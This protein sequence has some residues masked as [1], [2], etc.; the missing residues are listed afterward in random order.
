MTDKAIRVL[1]V[2]DNPGDVTLMK[3]MLAEAGEGHFAAESASSL[4]AGLERMAAG[5]IDVVL[6]DLT[7]PDAHGLETVTRVRK[8]APKIPVVVLTGLDDEELALASMHTGAQDY[9]VKGSV[10]C[11]LLARSIR[12]AVERTRTERELAEHRRRLEVLLDNV[13]DRIY[14]K[15]EKG[16]FLQVNASLASYHGVSSPVEVCGKTDAD[17]FAFEHANQALEDERE[18]M[19]TGKP[20]IGRVEKETFPDGRVG[21]SSSTK[22]P[23]RDESG[24]IVG[25]CGVS[26]DITSLMVAEEA[27]R[28]SEERYKRLLNSVTD[29][30]YTVEV[31]DGQTVSTSHGAGC[32]AV[33]GYSPDEF[34]ADPWLWH[35]VIHYADRERVVENV[36]RTTSEGASLEIEHRIVRRDGA[37]RWVR[38]KH[39]PRHDNAGKLISYDGLVSDITERKRARDEL[40]ETNAQLTKVLADLTKSHDDLKAAQSQLMQ[41]EKLH[42]IGQ[43]A[44]GVAHEV[45]NPLQVILVGLQ[46][47]NDLPLGAE[48]Q[49]KLVLNEMNDAVQRANVVIRDLLDFASPRELGMH[50][51]SMNTL[52][53]QSM[54]FVRHELNQAKVKVVMELDDDLPNCCVDPPKIEQV[55]VNLFTNACHAMPS[56]GTLT[57]RSYQRALGTE[58]VVHH[59]GDRSGI[60]FWAGERAIVIEVEDTGTGISS[61]KLEK[62]FDPFFTT[63]Q[64]GK[65]TGLGLTVTKKIIDLHR[66]QISI[67]NNPSGGVTVKIFLK[68]E[69]KDERNQSRSSHEQETN[70]AGG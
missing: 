70:T 50:E 51:R 67:Q 21:W 12:Y 4:S 16:R 49:T 19:R 55:L 45:K 59:H 27:V 61:D 42:S 41:A 63:K 35:R 47:L 3:V 25:T 36:M 9:L 7:L 32:L 38:N 62:V 28:S 57:V 40:V 24:A 68:A 66:G 1:M 14:F 2:E 10:D 15:D 6:L 18:I 54:R 53:R 34:K 20:L 23:L 69:N 5:D 31:K 26:R 52:I 30:V 44:A 11:R 22:M 46:Y 8:A 65:G 17:F 60:R 43:L 39:V 56:G 64:T 29:Y 33:T 37:I 58:E 48:D 13:P